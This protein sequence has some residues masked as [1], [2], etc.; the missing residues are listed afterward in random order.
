MIK[1]KR[2]F[3]ISAR[4]SRL[5]GKSERDCDFD[6]P[7]VSIING[8]PAVILEMVEELVMG[9]LDA[10]SQIERQAHEDLRPRTLIQNTHAKD[11]F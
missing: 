1:Y 6:F 2:F 10:S 3:E 9:S 11:D 5:V 7:S 4:E 8:H